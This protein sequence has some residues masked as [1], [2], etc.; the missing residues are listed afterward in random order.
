MQIENLVVEL[1][2]DHGAPVA[3]GTVGR[4]VL[5]DLHNLAQP[6]I[7]YANGDLAVAAPDQQ[8]CA[9]GRPHPRLASIEGRVTDT[10]RDR[11]GNPI[12]GMIFNLAFSPLAEAVRQFQAVQHTDGSITLRVVPDRDGGALP[13]AARSHVEQSCA[14]YLPGIPIAFEVVADIPPTASG[15]RRVVVVEAAAGATG[16]SGAAGAAGAAGA[17]PGAGGAPS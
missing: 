16:A 1:V 10:L 9:C 14:R 7:R 12:G 8:P 3:P 4:V 15:K 5:T 17:V 6:F 11:Q 13:P 2:D